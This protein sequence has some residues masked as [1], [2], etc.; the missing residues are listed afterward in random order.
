MI[1]I[2]ID[3]NGGGI[4]RNLKIDKLYKGNF[5]E[6]FIMPQ[7]IDISQFSSAYAIPFREISCLDN[8]KR[9]IEWGLQLKGLVVIRICTDSEADNFVRQ[10]IT[11]SLQEYIN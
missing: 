10:T 5:E 11:E 6:L 9:A 1:I 3:N 4:F 2:L 8:L 7:S